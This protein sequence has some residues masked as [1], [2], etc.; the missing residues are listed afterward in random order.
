MFS[1]CSLDV[2]PSP[3]TVDTSDRRCGAAWGGFGEVVDV[4]VEVTA[5]V[6][7]AR[8][9]EGWVGS[10]AELTFDAGDAWSVGCTVGDNILRGDI[11]LDR[12]RLDACCRV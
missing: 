1:Q 8:K 6:G 3:E 9:G 10:V 2:Q 7:P 5:G 11:G 4:D 12:A